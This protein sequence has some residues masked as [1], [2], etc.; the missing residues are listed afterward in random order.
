VTDQILAGNLIS[1][2]TRQLRPATLNSGK[3][4]D[5]VSG[6]IYWSPWCWSGVLAFQGSRIIARFSGSVLESP[7][8]CISPG[9]P[10]YVPS[11]SAALLDASPWL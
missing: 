7:C 1:E 6:H 9:V 5:G 2:P 11:R 4:S 3:V 10:G 8:F